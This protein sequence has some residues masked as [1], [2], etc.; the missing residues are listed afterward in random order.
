MKKVVLDNGVR[1]LLKR[2]D[3]QSVTVQVSMDV[4]SID[5][6]SG[7]K[8]YSHLVEHMLFEGT[9]RR[10]TAKIIAGEIE[11]VG[12]DFNAATSN[13][14]TNYYVKVSKEHVFLGID[15]LSD[16]LQ[17]SL[18]EEDNIEKEKRIVLEEIKMIQDQP[19]YFQ[20]LFFEEKLFQGTPYEIPVYGYEQDVK[21][22]TKE[23]LLS[24]INRTYTPKRCV[25]SVV[26]NF[27]EQKVLDSIQTYFGDWSND[28]EY[29]RQHYLPVNSKTFSEE[30]RDIQQ[31]YIIQGYITHGLC[32][33]DSVIIDVIESILG[34][35]QSGRLNEKIRGNFGYAYDIGINYECFHNFGFVAI[36]VGCDKQYVDKVKEILDIELKRLSTEEI[37][38]DELLYAKQYIEG[39][40]LLE[41]EDSHKETEVLTMWEFISGE[42][43]S[44]EHLEKIKNVT[45]KDILQFAISFFNENMTEIRI[46]PK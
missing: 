21:N 22:A 5:E 7:E 15:V 32:H 25:V 16:M 33:N 11:N 14:Q 42:D 26:G 38:E 39:K 12:G 46:I 13:E 28:S 43:K 20:W 4:G 41:L 3:G 40:Y 8:G 27:D 10:P 17:N 37:P 31:V 24:Y 35:P 34:K 1:V 30:K 19:R 18:F 36:N 29:E 2:K 44:Q 9:K 6:H 23:S 45:S